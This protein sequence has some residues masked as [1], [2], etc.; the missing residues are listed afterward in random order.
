MIHKIVLAVNTAEELTLQRAVA[1]IERLKSHFGEETI[2]E[3]V[4]YGPGLQFLM[5]QSAYQIALQTLPPLVTL[6]ACQNTIYKIEQKT[7]KKPNL[8]P[9]VQVVSGGL[10]RIVEL[11]EQ[12][13]AYLL[14]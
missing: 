8:L 11:Q 14:P 2:I 13:Y 9:A 12:G 4:A 10:V 5:T 6:S 1:S 3:I 7:G